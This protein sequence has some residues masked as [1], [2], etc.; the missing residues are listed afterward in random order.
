LARIADVGAT[1]ATLVAAWHDGSASVRVAARGREPARQGLWA[2]LAPIVSSARPGSKAL[3]YAI[4]GWT[5]FGDFIKQGGSPFTPFMQVNNSYALSSNNAWYPNLLGDPKAV[6]GGQS[7]DSWFNVNAFA[8]PT[9]GTFGNL[10][11][12]TL[13]G[14]GLTA[15]NMSLHK[16]FKFTERTN[17]DFSANATNLFNHPS[18]A[19]PDKAIGAGHVGRISLTSV[20]SRQMELVAKFRF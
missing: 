18:F 13:Y 16:V 11:R 14:P 15:V 1:A 5:L 10:G 19:L 4:G 17:L 2:A 9:P 3:D 8:S 6:A 20:G 7:I 12:N